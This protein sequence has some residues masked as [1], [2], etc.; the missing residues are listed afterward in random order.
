MGMIIDQLSSLI[1][2]MADLNIDPA[3]VRTHDDKNIAAIRASLEKF[4]QRQPI[5]VQKQGMIVRTGNGRVL[6]ARAMVKS[7]E[8]E[9]A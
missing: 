9:G 7:V 1:M 4:G 6:A 2:P 3:N 5:V 8:G